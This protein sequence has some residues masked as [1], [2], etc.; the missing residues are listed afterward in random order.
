MHS[1]AKELPR[2]RRGSHQKWYDPTTGRATVL[3]DWAAKDLKLG[4]VKAAINQLGIDKELF[5]QA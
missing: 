1:T 5:E 3:P 4:T 2:R